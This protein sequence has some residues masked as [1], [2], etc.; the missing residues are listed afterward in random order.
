MDCHEP[1]LRGTLGDR[2]THRSA[3]HLRLWHIDKVVF[4]AERL[5][6]FVLAWRE[7]SLDRGSI[8]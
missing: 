4:D 6:G 8:L 7:L 1:Q 3:N 5:C 2:L